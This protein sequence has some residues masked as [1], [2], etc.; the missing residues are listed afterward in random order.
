MI[1]NEHVIIKF[2]PDHMVTWDDRGNA[3]APIP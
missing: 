2:T 1:H 3:L